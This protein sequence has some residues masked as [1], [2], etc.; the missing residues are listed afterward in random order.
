M[1]VEERANPMGKIS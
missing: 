1:L